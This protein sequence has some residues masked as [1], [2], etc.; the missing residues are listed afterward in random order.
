MIPAGTGNDFIKTTKT[1][2]DPLEALA[3]ILEHTARPIDIGRLND[4]MFLNVCGTGYDV[5]VLDATVGDYEGDYRVGEHNSIPMLRMME[6]SFRT[7]EICDDKTLIV[8]DHIARTLHKPHDEL[9]RQVQGD[10]YLPAYD[11][12]RLSVQAK[13]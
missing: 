11:G 4:R 9:C 3:F 6:K 1:P 5:M 7:L 2:K 8:L 10:G 13:V 12:M